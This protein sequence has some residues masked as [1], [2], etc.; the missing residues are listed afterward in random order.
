[1]GPVVLVFLIL[2]TPSLQL[3][4]ILTGEFDL[5]GALGHAKSTG[6]KGV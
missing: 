1:L 5:V 4:K 2:R 6:V 3:S